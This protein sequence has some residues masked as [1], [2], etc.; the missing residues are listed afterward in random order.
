MDGPFALRAGAP[1]PF[2]VQKMPSDCEDLYLRRRTVLLAL[3]RWRRNIAC[4][5]S[6]QHR[7]GIGGFRLVAILA[8]FYV[9][10]RDGHRL[11]NPSGEAPAFK[12]RITLGQ[13][14]AL[15]ATPL[16][17]ASAAAT[18]TKMLGCFMCVSLAWQ[19]VR[20][21]VC[22]QEANA[23]GPRRGGGD[24]IVTST[25]NAEPSPRLLPKQHV[26]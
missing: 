24:E 26:S 3:A 22:C 19:T 8:F 25:K 1:D 9:G 4:P 18:I 21:G 7:S 6:F 15:C 11:G 13:S 2:A 23:E 12:F 5:A 10:Q 14:T 20:R 17:N 16:P